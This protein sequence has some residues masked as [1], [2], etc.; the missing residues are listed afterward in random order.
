MSNFLKTVSDDEISSTVDRLK[1]AGVSESDILEYR[2]KVFKENEEVKSF[3][4]STEPQTSTFQSLVEATAL[5]A[6]TLPSMVVGGGPQGVIV[7]GAGNLVAQGIRLGLGNQKEFKPADVAASGAYGAIGPVS[8]P[9]RMAAGLNAM[10]QAAPVAVPQGILSAM[11]QSAKAGAEMG[12][13][14]AA[15]EAGRVLR[16]EERRVGKEC[17]GRCRSRWSPYH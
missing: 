3:T 15:I 14:S 9:I 5:A 4:K 10:R 11:G 7:G 16:S 6:D 1:K 13:K 8:G 17:L 12:G 2:T